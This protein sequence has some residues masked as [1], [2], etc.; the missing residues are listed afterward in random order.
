MEGRLSPPNALVGGLRQE[1]EFP[2]SWN[3]I[4]A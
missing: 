3:D 4:K 2:L 1:N